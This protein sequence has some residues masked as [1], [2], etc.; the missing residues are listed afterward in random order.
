MLWQ[1]YIGYHAYYTWINVC[2]EFRTVTQ[3]FT[4]D[5][6]IALGSEPVSSCNLATCLLSKDDRNI[7]QRQTT[8]YPFQGLMKY[9][10]IAPLWFTIKHYRSVNHAK[11][12]RVFVANP[13]INVC[14]AANNLN[15]DVINM[16]TRP[17]YTKIQSRVQFCF[18]GLILVTDQGQCF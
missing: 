11:E 8:E 1:I 10:F 7:R 9:Y 12:C 3:V 14:L 2:I 15:I 6:V 13:K 5:L 4:H 16:H 18:L 17:A